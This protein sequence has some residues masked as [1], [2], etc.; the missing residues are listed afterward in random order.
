MK[1]LK[2]KY[3]RFWTKL[4]FQLNLHCILSEMVSG[5]LLLRTVVQITHSVGDKQVNFLQK[6]SILLIYRWPVSCDRLLTIT[7]PKVVSSTYTIKLF[8][9]EQ[10]AQKVNLKNTEWQM[11]TWESVHCSLITFIARQTS[12]EI[13]MTLLPI[14]FTNMCID[15]FGCFLN[16]AFS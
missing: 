3:W 2:P 4:H 8:C 10:A 1:T 12:L 15:R 6:C 13:F 14:L 11:W 16:K 7:V 5:S 9:D